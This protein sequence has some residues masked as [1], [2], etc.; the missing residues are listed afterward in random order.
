EL[1]DAFE[2]TARR[3]RF[4]RWVNE[5]A[6][7]LSPAAI[8]KAQEELDAAKLVISRRRKGMFDPDVK[9]IIR[10][11]PNATFYQYGYLREA[12]TLCFWERE[13]AQAR[14]VVTGVVEFV[15]GCIL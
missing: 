1:N 5:A 6:L 3:A 7:D 14:R 8:V 12:D 13:L 4:V 10:S 2:I 15:P 11:T 9:S